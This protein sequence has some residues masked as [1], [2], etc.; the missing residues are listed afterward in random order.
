MALTWHVRCEPQALG[1][2]GYLTFMGNEFGHP[3]WIDFPREGNGES[4]KHCRRL[5]HLADDKLLRCV[6]LLMFLA[7]CLCRRVRSCRHRQQCTD[8]CCRTASQV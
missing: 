4:F 3:E 5:W 2:E 7:L 6:L 8:S 1:G